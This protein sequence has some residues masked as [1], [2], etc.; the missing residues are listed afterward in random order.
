M[1]MADEI[2]GHVTEKVT[3]PVQGLIDVFSEE[4]ERPAVN[5][6]PFRFSGAFPPPLLPFGSGRRY[7]VTGLHHDETGFPTN[8]PVLADRQVRWLCD[9]VERYTDRLAEVEMIGVED[10]DILLFAYGGAARS[11]KGALR[12]ARERGLK[13]G[14]VRP[15]TL[16]PFPEK[17]IQHAARNCKV[18]LAAEMNLGQMAHEVEWAISRSKPV[19]RYNKVGGD[20]ILPEEL[21]E[22]MEGV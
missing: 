13:V 3:F 14:L 5:Y 2:V 12:L 8:D 1:I 6:R 21:L 4:Q 17:L 22:V 15:V 10:A 19:L 7:H 11:A 16:W 18:I 9:K 20:P